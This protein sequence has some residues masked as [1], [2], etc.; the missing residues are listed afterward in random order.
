MTREEAIIYAKNELAAATER[1]EKIGYKGKTKY[2][3]V[4]EMAIKTLENHD[5]F[6][7]HSYEQGKQDAVNEVLDKIRDEIASLP[8]NNI[9][10]RYAFEVIDQYRIIEIIDRHKK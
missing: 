8:T 10:R 7:R 1:A 3:E 9:S 5:T 6:M 2:I 4:L